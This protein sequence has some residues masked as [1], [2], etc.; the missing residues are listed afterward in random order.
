MTRTGDDPHD[1]SV[2]VVPTRE[3][4]RNPELLSR[5][6]MEELE[7]KLA[8][9]KDLP[10]PE[11]FRD[12]LRN[13]TVADVTGLDRARL[14]YGDSWKRRG[15][16]GAY[17]MLARKWD[18]LENAVQRHNWDVFEAAAADR[19]PEG[20]V[21]DIRDLRRYLLLVEEELLSRGVLTPQEPVKE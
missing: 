14:S 4:L 12:R 20:L 16:V 5:R 7:T 17:M 2:N 6:I 10:Q 13:I 18:R 3:E 15:G 21:D 11:S 9:R 1:V 8:E 19:R